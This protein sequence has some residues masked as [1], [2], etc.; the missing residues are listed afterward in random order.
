MT[1]PLLTT[2]YHGD[3]WHKWGSVELGSVPE[4]EGETGLT[5]V[6]RRWRLGC[7]DLSERVIAD[8]GSFIVTLNKNILD[9]I[10]AKPA[11][12][13]VP[14]FRDLP[15]TIFRNALLTDAMFAQATGEHR[16]QLNMQKVG[17]EETVFFRLLLPSGDR[18]YGIDRMVQVAH[19]APLEVLEDV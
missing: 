16:F 4:W 9:S 17:R 12:K 18:V 14:L 1:T 15:D 10:L 3:V 5:D 6:Y 8:P 19:V 13:S 7:S 2:A 11:E